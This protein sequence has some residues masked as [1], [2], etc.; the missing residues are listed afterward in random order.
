MLASKST[1]KN[2]KAYKS[3][4]FSRPSRIALSDFIR[5]QNSISPLNT[6]AI[7]RQNYEDHLRMLS[8]EKSK[9]CFSIMLFISFFLFFI[10]FW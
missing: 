9:N 3:Y 7:E 2:P 6:E 8:K 1:P 4:N 5:I 10:S